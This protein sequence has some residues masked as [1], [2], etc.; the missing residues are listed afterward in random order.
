[1]I[2]VEIANVNNGI[3]YYIKGT[4]I[5]H[6][7]DGPAKIFAHCKCWYINGLRHR[8]GG[9]AI[10]WTDG[11]K[12]WYSHGK[13]HRLDGPA[14]EANDGIKVWYVNGNCHREGGPAVEYTDGEKHWFM[15]GKRYRV[16]YGCGK[17]AWYLGDEF[18]STKEEWF[19]ALTENQKTKALY[20][21]YFI[22]G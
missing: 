14:I 7:D 20:S 10:E 1:M 11:T 2:E 17:V 21:E 9:P 3:V 4:C 19:E 6:R 22:G 8:E 18:F 16:L 13:R 12:E 5:L 15:H